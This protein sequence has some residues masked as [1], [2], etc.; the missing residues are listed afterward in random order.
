MSQANT[1]INTEAG[2]TNWK[3]IT[4]GGGQ[5]RGDSGGRGR[6]C[7]GDDHE[8]NLSAKYSF[9]GKMKDDH[10]FKLTITK[11]GL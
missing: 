7:C 9:E 6:G 1:N 10:I 4:E 3:Q 8:N 2:N 5:G 11:T